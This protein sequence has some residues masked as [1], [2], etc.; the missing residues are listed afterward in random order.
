M[1]SVATQNPITLVVVSTSWKIITARTM[2]TSSLRMPST[3]R[4]RLLARF[5]RQYSD[6]R[7]RKTKMDT[8]PRQAM[9]S[10][11]SSALMCIS[12]SFCVSK[13][14]TMG[15]RK[16]AVAGATRTIMEMGDWWWSPSSASPVSASTECTICSCGSAP[17]TQASGSEAGLRTPAPGAMGP[18]SPP[19]SSSSKP[20]SS[21]TLRFSLHAAISTSPSSS[22]APF[23]AASPSSSSSAGGASFMSTWLSAQRKPAAAQ[24]PSASRTPS[25]EFESLGD[26]SSPAAHIMMPSTTTRMLQ[27]SSTLGCSM[28][29]SSAKKSVKAGTVPLSIV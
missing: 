14:S 16:T 29:K 15:A 26:S 1:P 25:M 4:L 24:A 22:V 9:V 18:S 12:L 6:T 2:V 28:R 3:D 23:G 8:A 10:A 27:M 13:M 21:S 19:S 20:Y 17:R 5:T 7:S 11:Q